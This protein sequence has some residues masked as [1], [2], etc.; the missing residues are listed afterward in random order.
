MVT[1]LIMLNT[2]YDQNTSIGSWDTI[3]NPFSEQS[4]FS[5]NLENKV[6][7]T[8]FLAA[9]VTILIIIMLNTRHDQNPSIDSWDIAVKPI[10]CTIK[11]LWWPWEVGQ[12]H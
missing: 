11:V 7:V 6:K 2:N 10:F 1:L 4:K 9:M 12:G 8:E 3:V 5:G